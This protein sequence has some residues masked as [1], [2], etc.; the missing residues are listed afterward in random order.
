M[1]AGR[2]EKN[3]CH[4]QKSVGPSVIVENKLMTQSQ[5]KV[6]ELDFSSTMVIYIL[7]ITFA[8]DFRDE[9]TLYECHD[10][11]PLCGPLYK[12][13]ALHFSN[14]IQ[15]NNSNSCKNQPKA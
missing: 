13:S 5:N 3:F 15:P 1:H 7:F 4:H 10:S 14:L 2:T 12:L 6:N 9:I 8:F 11:R